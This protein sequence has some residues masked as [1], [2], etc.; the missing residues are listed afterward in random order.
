MCISQYMF[1]DRRTV[2]VN[3]LTCVTKYAEKLIREADEVSK[4]HY[5]LQPEQSAY[6]V[7]DSNNLKYRVDLSENSWSCLF[8]Q[9]VGIPCSHAL[10]TIKKTHEGVPYSEF[11]KAYYSIQGYRMA[12]A[13]TIN[14][15]LVDKPVNTILAIKRGGSGNTSEARRKKSKAS[16]ETRVIHCSLCKKSGHTK[17]LVKAFFPEQI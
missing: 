9:K 3:S 15:V 8:W 5:V 2:T 13:D 6:E 16:T 10:A 17:N 4:S 11:C 7:Q 14:L 12:Y 1:N